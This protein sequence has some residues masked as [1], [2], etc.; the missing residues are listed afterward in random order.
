VRIALFG[1]TFDPPHRGHIA[2]AKAAADTF[3]LDTVLF[4]PAGRQPLKPNSSGAEYADRLHMVQ[5]A[6]Q[7]DP[8][9]A[10]CTL[11]EPRADG[12]ANYTVDTL[13]TLYAD[14]NP[15]DHLFCIT[16]VDAFLDLPRWREPERLLTLAEW[17]VVSRPGFSMESLVRLTLL[18][19]QFARV[20]LLETV[21]QDVAATQLRQ[22]LAAGE[23]VDA[24]LAPGVGPYI[25]KQHLYT[26]TAK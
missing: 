18:P 9:F 3:Q 13:A 21:H 22:A 14:L 6:V 23:N 1:G 5:L 8:R 19:P 12:S 11:D 10:T 16:G 20:H 24:D 25:R 26:Q 15:G 17:I 7:S 4:A 2:V